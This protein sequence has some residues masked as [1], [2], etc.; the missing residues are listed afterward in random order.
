MWPNAL[1]TAA[2]ASTVRV[3][4]CVQGLFAFILGPNATRF[5]KRFAFVPDA[6]TRHGAEMFFTAFP[7]SELSGF[8]VNA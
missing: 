1:M 4:R 5:L 7:Q 8:A 2:P 6:G 3:W